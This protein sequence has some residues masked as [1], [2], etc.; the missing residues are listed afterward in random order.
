MNITISE[1]TQMI[2]NDKVLMDFLEFIMKE[3]IKDK[4]ENWLGYSST[5]LDIRLVGGAV[6][7]IADGRTPKDYDFIDNDFFSKYLTLNHVSKTAETFTYNHKSGPIKIQFLKTKTEDFDFTVAR[8]NIRIV[9]KKKS[10]SLDTMSDNQFSMNIDLFD[11]LFSVTSTL[12]DCSSYN[13]RILIPSSFDKKENCYNSLL[14]FKH[15]EKKG[16]T[17]PDVT[18]YSLLSSLANDKNNSKHS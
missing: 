16:F 3:T 17:L 1:I 7:D 12:P 13:S 18:Y 5:Y 2:K 11:I 8:N 4:G 9:A 6:I 14:R 15:W 10:L